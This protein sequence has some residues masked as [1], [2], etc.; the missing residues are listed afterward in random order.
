MDVAPTSRSAELQGRTVRRLLRRGARGRISK[1][2]S[3]IRPEDVAFMLRTFTP[4]EQFEV[5]KILVSDFRDA[6]S[7]VLL[8]MDPQARHGILSQLTPDQVAQLLDDAKV[9]DAVFILDSLPDELKDQVFAIVDL[10]ER[11]SDVQAHLIYDD[12]TAGRIM[13]TQF[14]ALTED[15]VV[16]EAIDRVR[17]FAQDVEMISY[18]YVV[19]KNDRLVGVTPLR[20][21]LLAQPSQTL[22]EIMNPSIVQVHTDTDQEEVAQQAARYDLLAIPVVDAENRLV[23]IVTI[24]DIVDIFKDEATEDF[25]KMVGT[26]DDELVYQD[27]SFKVAGIRL[28]WILFNLVGLLGA[29]ILTT[30]F[31]ETFNMAV[32]IGFIPVIMGMAGNIGSQTSTIAVRGLAT[33]RLSL[34]NDEIRKFLWQQL[35]VGSLLGITCA[36]LVAFASIGMAQLTDYSAGHMALALAVS[37]SLFATV[38][39][40]SLNGVLIP[41][42]FQRLGFDPAVASG[43]LVTTANDVLGVLIYFSLTAALFQLMVGG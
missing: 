27:R 7:D 15:T 37:L 2:L 1:V 36:V 40:A 18:L 33:G 20:N 10:E 22:D 29:G 35:K 30:R 9:D 14:M 39:L 34:N 28:P 12:D 13:D 42:V 23:G 3:K 26:S 41:V 32:L 24:D 38:I 19:D 16:Q 25:Y 31:E 4:M 17:D 5:F 21:L 6:A 8:E 11:F 43:P